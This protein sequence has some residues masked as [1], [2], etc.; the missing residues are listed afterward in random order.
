MSSTPGS[1][2]SKLCVLFLPEV[3]IRG[4]LIYLGYYVCGKS[5]FPS[6]SCVSSGSTLH[7]V[8]LSQEKSTDSRSYN[9]LSPYQ[10]KPIRVEGSIS[11]RRVLKVVGGGEER[12]SCNPWRPHLDKTRDHVGNGWNHRGRGI[13]R[14]VGASKGNITY[15]PIFFRS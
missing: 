5:L 15:I 6:D 11:R 12:G 3:C 4:C 1:V 9:T 14:C 2:T 10:P 7:L 13:G 8:T